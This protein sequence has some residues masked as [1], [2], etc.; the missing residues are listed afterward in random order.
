LLGVGSRP[1]AHRDDVDGL[2]AALAAE[3]DRTGDQREQGVVLAAAD[4][5][6]RVELGAPLTDQDLAALTVCPPNRLIPNR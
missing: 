1:K 2:P 6:A 3:L 4:A 5:L